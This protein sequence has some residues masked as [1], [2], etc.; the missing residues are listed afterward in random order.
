M[1]LALT[2]PEASTRACLK[3]LPRKLLPA[4]LVPRMLPIIAAII[5]VAAPPSLIFHAALQGGKPKKPWG[6]VSFS[7][8]SDFTGGVIMDVL[9]YFYS[10]NRGRVE[11]TIVLAE[12]GLANGP[13]PAAG[14]ESRVKSFC[15]LIPTHPI[16]LA[17]VA[18]R[19]HVVGRRA[20]GG[21]REANMGSE[22]RDTSVGEWNT[23]R[24]ESSRMEHR[25]MRK[26]ENGTQRDAKVGEWTGIAA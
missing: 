20:G 3:D 25:E 16:F 5:A 18:R 7:R 11:Q 4:S 14:S 10:P 15:T 23:E 2:L 26:L 6:G 8:G 13:G 22:Q 1:P 21:G 12:K 9:G 24:C 19:I 17:M